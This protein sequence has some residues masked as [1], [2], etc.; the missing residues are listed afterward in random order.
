MPFVCFDISNI[1]LNRKMA[2]G[3]LLLLL[4]FLF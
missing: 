4:A 2:L 3:K 1:Q